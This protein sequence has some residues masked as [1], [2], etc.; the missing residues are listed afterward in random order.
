MLRQQFYSLFLLTGL[1][2][3]ASPSLQGQTLSPYLY[4]TCGDQVIAGSVML[5]YSIGEPLVLAQTNSGLVLTQGFQQVLPVGP[6]SV[7]IPDHD[8]TVTIFPNP[9]SDILNLSWSSS[10]FEGDLINIAIRNI[11]G[12]TVLDRVVAP[13]PSLRTTLD[14]LG[15][16]PSG[17]YFV[18]LSNPSSGKQVTFPILKIHQP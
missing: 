16:L 4:S 14:D 1:L 17:S 12:Q 13:S 9:F 5:S 2:Y 15:M 8:G 3:N 11:S 7:Q 18:C 6:V 10:W